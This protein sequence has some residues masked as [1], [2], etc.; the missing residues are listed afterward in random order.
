V[1]IESVDGVASVVNRL[2]PKP[3]RSLV[4]IKHCPCHIQEISILSLHN[5]VLLRCVGRRELMV[6]ALLLKKSFNLRI[7]ELCSIV[8]SN[9]IDSQSELILSPSQE[10]LL[11]LLGLRFSCKKNIQV[12]RE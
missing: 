2:R 10:S 5:T 4:L 3:I 11:G 6:D 9:L 8:A 12:K 7:L 1:K